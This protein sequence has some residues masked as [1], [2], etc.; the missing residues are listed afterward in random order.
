[1]T[2][3][4]WVRELVSCLKSGADMTDEIA[5]ELADMQDGFASTYSKYEEEDTPELALPL[6]DLMMEALQLM[7]NGVDDVLDFEEEGDLAL[8][9]R[10]L[11]SIEEGNDILDSLKYAIEKDTSWA[12]QASLG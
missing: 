10:G 9:T 8:L 1:M 3:V 11:A 2:F 12:G 4:D 7:H 5:N 6:R